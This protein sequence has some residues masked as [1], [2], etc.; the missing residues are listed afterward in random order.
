M[1][2]RARSQLYEFESHCYYFSVEFSLLFVHLT[3]TRPT[4]GRPSSY[5]YTHDESQLHCNQQAYFICCPNQLLIRSGYLLSL[6]LYPYK[7]D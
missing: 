5:I 1:S 7:M 4:K 2:K 6:F 3:I